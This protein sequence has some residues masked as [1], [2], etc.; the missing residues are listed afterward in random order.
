[1]AV[2]PYDH[3]FFFRAGNLQGV[4]RGQWKLH[5]PHNYVTLEGGE[6]GRDGF[7]GVYASTALG[8]SLFDLDTDVGEQFNV[9]DEHPE[10]VAE[11]LKLIEQG[12]QLLGD[13]STNTVGQESN[14]PGRVE[15][16]WHV[17]RK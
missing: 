1:M 13:R 7:P 4:R 10:I 12:R 17:Q 16:P 9:I 14:E 2:S 11:L 8:L 5:V 15:T 3:I 6:A